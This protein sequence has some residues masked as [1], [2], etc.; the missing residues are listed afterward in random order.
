[1]S[2]AVDWQDISRRLRAPFDPADV[3]F[4]VQGK[5]G[6]S[7]KAQILAYVDARAVQD[8]L[9]EVAGAGAW[10]FDWT[11][12][13]IEQGDVQVAKGTLTIHGVSKSDAGTASN[14][15]ESL[16]AVSHCFKRAAVMWGI[17]RY[18][19]DL[20]A[21]WESVEGNGRIPAQTLA[22]M[23]ARLPRPDGTV[24]SRATATPQPQQ[25]AQ[26]QPRAPKPAS[27][28]AP[29]Q[30]DTGRTT[31]ASADGGE[32][33]APPTEQQA[34]VIAKLCEQLGRPVPVYRT[35]TDASR[36]IQQL[37]AARNPDALREAFPA[38]QK[39]A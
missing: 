26:S 28:P 7:G 13:V 1:M 19:Y 34:R 4:R 9:D 38:G 36:L 20:P 16:G 2:E 12:L 21:T 5:P 29:A 11:P 6:Q 3:D 39:G 30:R 33:I 14:F 25:P 24:P 15:A 27:Q 8:R 32:T 35:Y 10:A 17:G 22:N 18:L 23:R 37:Q 31:A